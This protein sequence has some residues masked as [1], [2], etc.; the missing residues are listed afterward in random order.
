MIT[1]FRV[2][3]GC[4]YQCC[5][6]LEKVRAELFKESNVVRSLGRTFAVMDVDQD[7]LID[8]QEFYWGLKNLGSSI[9]KREAS[10]LLDYLDTS[11]DGY[12]DY[13]EF[14]A[15][16]RGS[17]SEARCAAIEAA[18]KKFDNYGAGEV[19]VT[20]LGQVF[21]CPDHPAVKSGECT[22]N[23]VFVQFLSTFGS[24]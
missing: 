4:C 1:Q 13:R 19:V 12:I 18:F 22:V 2:S 10:L 6:V 14:L 8:K 20:E 11:K 24:K 7:R 15:G 17:P 21:S 5:V 3:N 23:D 16:V 9:S